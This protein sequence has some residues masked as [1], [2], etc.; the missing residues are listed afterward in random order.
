VQA[1]HLEPEADP[2]AVG[3]ALGEELRAVARW[4]SLDDIAAPKK[5]PLSLGL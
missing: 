3:P 4:L 2:E 1:L 5:L